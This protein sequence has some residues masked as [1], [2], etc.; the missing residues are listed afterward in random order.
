VQTPI[1]HQEF[2]TRARNLLKIGTR[3]KLIR[4]RA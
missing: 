1:D 2:I 3:Q 4:S